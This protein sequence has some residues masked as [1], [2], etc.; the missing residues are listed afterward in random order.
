M[1]ILSFI[2]VFTAIGVS[3]LYVYVFEKRIYSICDDYEYLFDKDSFSNTINLL[4]K[5][6]YEFRE[7]SLIEKIEIIQTILRRLICLIIV[8]GIVLT[9]AAKSINLFPG[10]LESIQSLVPSS[11]VSGW[12]MIGFILACF[13]FISL[14]VVYF[15]FTICIF[16]VIHYIVSNIV[17]AFLLFSSYL[18]YPFIMHCILKFPAETD[19]FL[20]SYEWIPLWA[21]L[22]ILSIALSDICDLC[23]FLIE[24]IIMLAQKY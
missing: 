23:L 3:F 6:F 13:A 5:N 20:I 9:V 12:M 19:C 11:V 17:L 14:V 22:S 4:G 15:W 10:Y 16:I 21:Y 8:T 18:N 7:S 1:F 2:S 24:K